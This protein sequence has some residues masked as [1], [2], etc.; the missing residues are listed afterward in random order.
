MPKNKAKTD[1]DLTNTTKESVT[2]EAEIINSKSKETEMN[3]DNNASSS[4]IP[5][6][7]L[8]KE[9][10]ICIILIKFKSKSNF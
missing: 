9:V 6:T 1:N 8:L 7:P 5:Q 2:L 3:V 4:S 10:C